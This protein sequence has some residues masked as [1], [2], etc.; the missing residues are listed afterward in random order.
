MFKVFQY[1]EVKSKILL[2]NLMLFLFRKYELVKEAYKELFQ[3]K[4]KITQIPVSKEHYINL[5]FKLRTNVTYSGEKLLLYTFCAFLNNFYTP[6]T[7]IT[8][9]KKK[10]ACVKSKCSLKKRS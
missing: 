5:F 4:N 7:R 10:F 2:E 8:I 3:E 1:G 9:N 6:T